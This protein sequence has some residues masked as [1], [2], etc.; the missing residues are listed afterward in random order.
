MVP[1][2]HDVL[3][4]ETEVKMLREALAVEN[5]FRVFY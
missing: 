2:E 1:V 4:R 5:M 3:I